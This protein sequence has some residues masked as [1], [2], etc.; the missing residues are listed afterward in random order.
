MLQSCVTNNR[1]FPPEQLTSS[2]LRIF[3]EQKMFKKKS[4]RRVD[5][6]TDGRFSAREQSA[7]NADGIQAALWRYCAALLAA[8]QNEQLCLLKENQAPLP[9]RFSPAS[10][11]LQPIPPSSWITPTLALVTAARR[12]AIKRAAGERG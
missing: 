12:A 9:R 5:D 10:I 2:V 4:L 11:L 6:N 3:L 8:G 1:L 7:A